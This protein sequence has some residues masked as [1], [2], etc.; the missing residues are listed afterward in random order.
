MLNNLQEDKRIISQ[1]TQ[2]IK[3]IVENIHSKIAHWARIIASPIIIEVN[4][5]YLGINMS[6]R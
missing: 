2:L 6:I 4:M 3:R 5:L 1:L